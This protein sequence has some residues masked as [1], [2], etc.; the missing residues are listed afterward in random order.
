M[1]AIPVAAIVKP[2]KICIVQVSSHSRM[3]EVGV[4]P[5]PM[6]AEPVPVRVTRRGLPHPPIVTGLIVPV[7]LMATDWP[8]S[9]IMLQ[10][11]VYA[12]ARVATALPLPA[13]RP[14]LL[15][16]PALA[17]A[18]TVMRVFGCH[19]PGPRVTFHTLET[20]A[21]SNESVGGRQY[22]P[23][24]ESSGELAGAPAISWAREELPLTIRIWQYA[25][26]PTSEAGTVIVLNA[27]VSTTVPLQSVA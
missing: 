21:T 26:K 12:C 10:A 5:S 7:K 18:N 9:G 8:L 11:M 1:L 25:G 13:A 19:G 22:P 23:Q 20:M 3:P 16:F 4:P 15:A 14:S 6:T 24:P 27:P 2:P 17:S